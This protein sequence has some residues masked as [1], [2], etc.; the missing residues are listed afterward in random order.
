METF[1]DTMSY[2][3]DGLIIP[4]EMIGCL[5]YKRDIDWLALS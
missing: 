4:Q 3:R 1:A 5:F 2:L